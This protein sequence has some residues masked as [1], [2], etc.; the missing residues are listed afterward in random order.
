MTMMVN[1]SDAWKSAFPDAH[2][3]ILVMRGVTNP[4]NHAELENRKR[5]LENQLRAQFAGGDRKSIHALASIR[6]YN[7]YYKPFKKT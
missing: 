6:A 5:H 1:V 2:A 7:A 4:P 3:G